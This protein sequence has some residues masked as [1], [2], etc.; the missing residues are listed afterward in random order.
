MREANEPMMPEAVDSPAARA[1]PTGALAQWLL[2]HRVSV[3]TVSAIS[4]S[5]P[6][7]AGCSLGRWAAPVVRAR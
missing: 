2:R 4:A 3:P 7:R 6:S 5:R 1:Q